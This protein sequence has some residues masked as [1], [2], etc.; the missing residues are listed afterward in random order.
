[1]ISDTDGV[2]IKF[3]VTKSFFPFLIFRFIR[4]SSEPMSTGDAMEEQIIANFR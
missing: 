1:M 4:L 2:S 3:H